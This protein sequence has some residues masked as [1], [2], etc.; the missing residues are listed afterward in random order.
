M[1]S[2]WYATLGSVYG[3]FSDEKMVNDCVDHVISSLGN[4]DK[5]LVFVIPSNKIFM[6]TNTN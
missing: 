4:V 2:G 6:D 5:I 1:K 3:D